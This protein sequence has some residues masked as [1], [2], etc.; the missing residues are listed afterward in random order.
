MALIECNFFS[1]TLG[2]AMTMKV[3]L[4][5]TTHHQIGLTNQSNDDLPPVL[6]LLHGLSDDHTIWLRRTAIERYVAPLGLAVVMPAVHKSYYSNLTPGD[7]Y[8]HYI[9]H[10]VPAKVQQLFRVSTDR[11]KTFVAGLSMGGYGAFKLALNYPDHFAAAASLSGALDPA[12]FLNH[13]D[14]DAD[15]HLQLA[16][17]SPE[18]FHHTANDLFHQ[19]E[20]LAA[21]DQ[22]KP[23][24]FQCC[25]RQDFLYDQN[26]RFRDFI[27]DKG[28]DY[29]YEE[30]DGD[31]EWGYWDTHIQRVLSWLMA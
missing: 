13:A 11:A 15:P 4:P 21:S 27:S 23:R 22:P 24:L 5:E 19:T 26:I 1:D 8:F 18:A 2:Q 20:Q 31:H 9:S 3:I 17:G 6:Y 10:E 16:F 25:G 12:E 14:L 30:S 7:P 29:H 28:F